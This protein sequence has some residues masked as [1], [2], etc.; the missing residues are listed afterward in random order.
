MSDNIADR[1]MLDIAAS[2]WGEKIRPMQAT[3][4]MQ[5]S[6]ISELQRE[7]D[8]LSGELDG[9]QRAHDQLGDQYAGVVAENDRLREEIDRLREILRLTQTYEKYAS[10]VLAKE[11]RK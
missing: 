7:N 11:A 6:A 10:A 1:A 3:I 4:E 5:L 2:V 8:R 9:L